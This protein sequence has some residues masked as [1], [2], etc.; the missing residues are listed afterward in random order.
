VLNRNKSL[1]LVLNYHLPSI[2]RLCTVLDVGI[3][4][5]VHHDMSIRLQ[6]CTFFWRGFTSKHNNISHAVIVWQKIVYT[7]EYLFRCS[8]RTFTYL[9]WI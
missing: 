3:V 2:Y 5:K 7:I 1:Y 6:A 8:R 4:T 9:W